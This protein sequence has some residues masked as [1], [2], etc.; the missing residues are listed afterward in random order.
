M[1]WDIQEMIHT[2]PFEVFKWFPFQKEGH[3][4]ELWLEKYF[5]KG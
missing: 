1:S 5:V 4:D 2:Q 3:F